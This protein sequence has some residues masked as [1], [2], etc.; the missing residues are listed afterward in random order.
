MADLG[1]HTPLGSCTFERQEFDHR[2]VYCRSVLSW[3]VLFVG[4]AIRFHRG[5]H[6]DRKEVTE[7]RLEVR[8]EEFVQ[9]VTL[10]YHRL[11]GVVWEHLERVVAEELWPTMV[12]VC[13]KVALVV[14]VNLALLA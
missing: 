8:L 10:G 6:L 11:G 12:G 13:F 5:L 2:R 4:E 7:C 1:N 3:A 14:A 9:V